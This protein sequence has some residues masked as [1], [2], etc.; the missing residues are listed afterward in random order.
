MTQQGGGVPPFAGCRVL[1]TWPPKNATMLHSSHDTQV[2]SRLKNFEKLFDE[3]Q[4]EGTCPD[5]FCVA[6]PEHQNVFTES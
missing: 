4:F 6:K 3:F 2:N 5:P 1:C